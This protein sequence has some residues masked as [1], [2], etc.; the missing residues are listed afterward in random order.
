LLAPN[1][2]YV[3]PMVYP[4]HW[5]AGEY[6]VADPVRQPADI[7]AASLADFERI[8]AGSGAAVVPWLQD[9][10]VDGVQYGSADVTAQITAA[11]AAGSEGFLLWN[12]T[13]TYHADALPPIP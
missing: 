4:S 2:D 7:V 6:A 8:I 5:G 11:V 10:S 13:S 12:P 1:V 9:F 3:A